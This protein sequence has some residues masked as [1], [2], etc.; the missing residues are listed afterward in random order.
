M[1]TMPSFLKFALGSVMLKKRSKTS[2]ASF[3]A[4]FFPRRNY[5]DS[6][7]PV[8]FYGA[9]MPDSSIVGFSSLRLNL[10]LV[11]GIRHLATALSSFL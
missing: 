4:S 9:K 8:D 11:S 7:E 5:Q 6:R 3:Y 1:P 10:V 2:S